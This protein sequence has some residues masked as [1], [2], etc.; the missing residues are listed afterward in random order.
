M[1]HIVV[2]QNHNFLNDEAEFLEGSEAIDKVNESNGDSELLYTV[3]FEGGSN[4]F[5][6]ASGEGTLENVQP[7]VAQLFGVFV[8]IEQKPVSL[9]E[10]RGRSFAVYDV[11]K[12][13]NV[14]RAFMLRY[15]LRSRRVILDLCDDLARS[16]A[17]PDA[18]SDL[19]LLFVRELGNQIGGVDGELLLASGLN[20]RSRSIVENSSSMFIGTARNARELAEFI[21]AFR[22]LW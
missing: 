12:E 3:S 18:I 15:W 4:L 10:F 21:T 19:L 20:D 11:L 8:C 13:R 7:R 5:S 14:E 6:L 2:A 17:L 1:P 9:V 22:T 16:F